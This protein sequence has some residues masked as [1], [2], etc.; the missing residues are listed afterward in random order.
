MM[1]T[2]PAR[3]LGSL[4]LLIILALT[5]VSL[6]S[7]SLTSSE[8]APQPAR[9]K[10]S[11]YTI[12]GVRYTP[13]TPDKAPGFRE[14]GIASHYRSRR[15]ASGEPFRANDL[16][17]AHKLLPL[18]SWVE[19]T[20]LANNRTI[21]VRINDRGPF[22]PGRV[23]DLTP[24]AAKKLG[25]Y[26]QG[27]TQVRLRVLSVGRPPQQRSWTSSPRIGRSYSVRPEQPTIQ[28]SFLR[29]RHRSLQRSQA[30]R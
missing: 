25:F 27:L 12:R 4:A 17:G 22:I 1:I 18:P 28:R 2:C 15:T 7:C 26:S 3:I 9:M 11:P 19:V 23:I 30:L 14:Q 5:G 13:L 10:Y 6:N 24:R 29:S 16:A 8:V 21:V 20:N